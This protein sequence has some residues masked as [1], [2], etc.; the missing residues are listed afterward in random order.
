MTPRVLLN[1]LEYFFKFFL[2]QILSLELEVAWKF[3]CVIIHLWWSDLDPLIWN[4]WKTS[5]DFPNLSQIL[6]DY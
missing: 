2:L 5:N 1:I 3:V 4:F 6:L